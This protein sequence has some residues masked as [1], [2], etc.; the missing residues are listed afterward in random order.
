MGDARE[1][2]A[3]RLTELIDRSGLR[4]DQ[5]PGRV[6]RPAGARWQI[7]AQRLSDW[8]AGKNVPNKEPAAALVRSLITR[9]RER[10]VLAEDV[11]KG[12]FDEALWQS[13]R[14]K[15]RAH[16]V[17]NSAAFHPRTTAV[18]TDATEPP[19]NV[20]F[21][22]DHLPRLRHLTEMALQEAGQV[23]WDFFTGGPKGEFAAGLY[24]HRELENVL[25][26]AMVAEPGRTLLVRGEPGYGKTSLL[27]GLSARLL[28]DDAAE[29]FLIK[30][31]WLLGPAPL[32]E[33]V[34][35]EAA[36]RHLA[37][38]GVR[39]T[40][41]ID[42]ADVLAGDERAQLALRA[43]V[44][45]V[46]ERGA[47]VV[48]TSRPA[49]ANALPSFWRGFMLGPY[50]TGV[51]PDGSLSEFERAVAA[52]ARLYC[53]TR[54]QA[55]KLA[56]QLL[57]AVARR[58]PIEPLCR[59]PLTLR[60]LSE[61]YSP[62]TVPST[63]DVTGLY[64][65]YWL[66][67]VQEDRRVGIAAHDT[68]DAS[69]NLESCAVE[70]ALRMLRVGVPQTVLDAD[71]RPRRR[72]EIALLC[73]RGVGAVSD[74]EFQFFH[75]TFFEYAAARGL[76]T[77]YGDHALA[78]LRD[79]VLAYPAD[80]VR[81]AVFEQTWL[82]AWRRP[83][84]RPAAVRLAQE[85]L[86]EGSENQE[87]VPYAVRRVI[88]SVLFQV[89]EVP[90]ILYAEWNRLIR[91]SDVSMLRDGLL[92]APAPRRHF[93]DGDVEILTHC[94]A[95]DDAIWVTV[96]GVLDRLADRDPER[97]DDIL[98]ALGILEK[99]ESLPFTELSARY[100]LPSLLAKLAV[101]RPEH[102][103]AHLA[104]LCRLAVRRRN[105]AYLARS[106][107]EVRQAKIGR[108]RLVAEWADSVPGGGL[109]E[110]QVLVLAYAL[111]HRD[112]IL[113]EAEDV[114]WDAPLRAL[115]EL[116]DRKPATLDARDRAVFGGILQAFAD[117]APAEYAAPLAEIIESIDNLGLFGEL[118]RGWL[119]ALI[120]SPRC[121]LRESA[122]TW[123]VSG[124]PASHS[125]PNDLR[126]RL[127]DSVR[128]A[129]ERPDF[130]I[131]VAAEIAAAAVRRID[132]T[133]PWL[134]PDVM[135]RLVIRA[136]V[137]QIPEA[138]DAVHQ[139]SDPGHSLTKAAART[140][141]QK[142]RDP[143]SDLSEAELTIKLALDRE[144]LKSLGRL[145][146]P[147][148]FVQ[149]HQQVLVRLINAGHGSKDSERQR[150]S[151]ELRLR[152]AQDTGLPIPTWE[153]L[154]AALDLA[155]EPRTGEALVGL[156]LHGAVRRDYGY[157][158]ARDVLAGRLRKDDAGLL[159]PENDVLAARRALVSLGAVLGAPGESAALLN[160][161]FLGPVDG[162]ALAKASS[163][164]LTSHRLGPHL[165]GEQS[166]EFLL[167]M[168]RRLVAEG[169]SESVRKDNAA[170][171]R[172]A[173]AEAVER[174]SLA[175]RLRILAA[176]PELD[177]QL[178]SALV[179][180]FDLLGAPAIR[181]GLARLID[182]PR[183][184]GQVRRSARIALQ[185]T[186][187]TSDLWSFE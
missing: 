54:Q 49:E 116:V 91:A 88:L 23:P 32:V 175:D 58:Q 114:G 92:L 50:A 56:D 156:I 115:R 43:L 121:S 95:R 36:V 131:S 87:H 84:L 166:T 39:C 34:M 179:L 137:A 184:D 172:P 112:R 111:L 16:R 165:T 33:S 150:L 62:G 139:L 152:L 102:A 85:L 70:L 151:A 124:L 66:D 126:Q 104:R 76:L 67:R 74:G 68:A 154:L 101:A 93:S 82:C 177:P 149:E 69:E 65:T 107:A 113:A 79:R 63:V 108:P 181:S 97:A 15:A 19:V 96:L 103:L 46:T 186:P 13:W 164:L 83:E 128:R 98:D 117:S 47:S 135:L 138:V 2:Y 127:A 155:R 3:E 169:V 40:V 140:V 17:N 146:L 57:S 31:V 30:S 170:R 178:A 72:K 94:V 148:S 86:A 147:A 61:L 182:D 9:A 176:T 53:G 5:V 110:E 173:L 1:F 153:E 21:A 64:E 59:R 48:V 27:W 38:Q 99:A 37:E 7:N 158:E 55:E 161:A 143:V 81:L 122:V 109:G 144:D 167:A 119:A 123:L 14:K 71:L 142:L 77:K 20:V 125:R 129:L 100:E 26:D 180:K 118:H 141:S 187:Q 52:H 11:T 42:T 90:T 29:V 89:S 130:P 106:F 10:G 4:I 51:G 134:D 133:E 8:Q 157:P 105:P 35:L 18:L 183:T 28:E 174:A 168:G 78:M 22:E 120:A 75:Q 162:Q 41:L 6:S 73:R 163:F 24:V 25:L 45:V 160:V 44:K 136:A 159:V 145:E 60:M 80:Y 185:R 171:W 12:L 132:H